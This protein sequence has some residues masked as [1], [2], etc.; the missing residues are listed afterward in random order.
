MKCPTYQFSGFGAAVGLPLHN[1]SIVACVG[2][3]IGLKAA[4]FAGE[5]M[6][7]SAL[8]VAKKP[9]ILK[10]AWEE[11]HEDYKTPYKCI[12]PKDN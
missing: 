9:E 4:M 6:A 7:Q 11:F 2:T 1:W 8:E 12:I 10:A 5:A 3:D